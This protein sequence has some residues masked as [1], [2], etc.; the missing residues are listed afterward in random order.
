MTKKGITFKG[1]SKPFGASG[2]F[3]EP[4][5][6]S[7]Q[8]KGFK[9]G[10]HIEKTKFLVPPPAGSECL[11]GS[12]YQIIKDKPEQPKPLT[13]SET[14]SLGQKFAD[15]QFKKMVGVGDQYVVTTEGGGQPPKQYGLMGLCGFSSIHVTNVKD[16]NA[17]KKMGFDVSK[18]YPKGF[19]FNPSNKVSAPD[20]AYGKN[21]DAGA[22]YAQ[23]MDIKE[24]VNKGIL[25]EFQ[26]RG[27]L[28]DAYVT[29]H[30]D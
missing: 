23:S 6:H 17:L 24:A 8:A 12:N 2:H 1:E 3:N 27:M 18:D 7:L 20:W 29:S 28:K 14:S 13:P 26:K 4:R 9:T 25:F 19:Y 16:A 15:E 30:L 21:K 22:Y 5:R 10:T 11:F